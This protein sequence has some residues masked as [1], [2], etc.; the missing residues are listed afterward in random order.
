MKA[1][2]QCGNE[3]PQMVN[4]HDQGKVKLSKVLLYAQDA[5]KLWIMTLIK[6]R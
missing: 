5:N 2:S 1:K 3:S 4:I 6:T